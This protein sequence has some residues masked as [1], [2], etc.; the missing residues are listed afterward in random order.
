M[1]LVE[2]G[3]M[4]ETDHLAAAIADLYGG[5]LTQFTRR[6]T[7]LA[8]QARISGDSAAAKAITA[9]RKPTKAA[10]VVNRLFRSDPRAATQ[11]SDLGAELR[12]VQRSADAH[13]MR[14]LTGT[15][16]ELVDAL[17]DQAF[18]AALERSPTPALR[19]EVTATLKAALA[20][21]RVTEMMTQGTLLK[22]V[23]WDGFGFPSAPELSVVAGIPE[24]RSAGKHEPATPAV[25]AE[26]AAAVRSRES[27]VGLDGADRTRAA[28][29]R[30][31][32]AADRAKAAAGRKAGEA[33]KVQKSANAKKATEAAAAKELKREEKSREIKAAK[34]VAAATKAERE[35]QD[36][37]R[38]LRDE[39]DTARQDLEKAK[40]TLRRATIAQRRSAQGLRIV[41]N[42]TSEI[43]EAENTSSKAD[44]DGG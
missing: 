37:V 5:D 17:S 28:A 36:T 9:L 21:A 15:R 40:Q 19:E 33:A 24:D 11:L 6:R 20:D 30:A 32:A 13:Q 27:R 35:L 43:S 34:A 31:E 18:E 2:S 39:L 14:K 41:P 8:A 26:P 25:L 10:F 23:E 16:K 22:S 12:A 29:D 4:S 7:A 42:G 1:T 3:P 44:R 38:R